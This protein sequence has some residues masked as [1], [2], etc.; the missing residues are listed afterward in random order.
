MLIFTRGIPTFGG[1]SED[2][3]GGVFG[4][5]PMIFSSCIAPIRVHVHDMSMYS[6]VAV[7]PFH[8]LGIFMENLI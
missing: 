5:F 1:A 4:V 8:K 6:S 3:A 2:E 7:L